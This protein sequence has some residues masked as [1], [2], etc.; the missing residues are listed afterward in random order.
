[1]PDLIREAYRRAVRTG[2]T[3]YGWST[4]ARRVLADSVPDRGTCG[5]RYITVDS[6]GAVALYVH[7]APADQW[8][9]TGRATV[10]RTGQVIAAEEIA[11]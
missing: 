3:V 1:M 4:Y 11:Q 10:D 9:I 2:A 5:G 8:R 6:A 7:D